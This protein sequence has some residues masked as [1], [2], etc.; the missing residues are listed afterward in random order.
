M[1]SAKPLP[2]LYL[3]FSVFKIRKLNQLVPKAFSPQTAT[4]R[5]QMAS[6]RHDQAVCSA[7]Q[8]GAAREQLRGLRLEEAALKKRFT[9]QRGQ[10]QVWT[11][12]TASLGPH[13][14]GS[15]TVRKCV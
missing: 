10:D 15:G 8:H 2:T 4:A 5:G 7:A 3:N 6:G 1:A 11:K 12:D 9:T 13:V 14:P